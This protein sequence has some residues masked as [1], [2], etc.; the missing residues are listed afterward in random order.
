MRLVHHPSSGEPVV[1]ADRVEQATSWSTRARGLMFRR[2][3][4]EGSALV[5]RFDTVRSRAIHMLFVSFAID[6]VWLDGEVVTG[7]KTLRP[8]I[9]LA[10]GRGDT[11]IECPEGTFASV[12]VGDRLVIEG[13]D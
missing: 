2:S 1:L 4:P 7:K 6:A 13:T 11:I 5:F 8:W 3:F 10:R 9:G 12:S